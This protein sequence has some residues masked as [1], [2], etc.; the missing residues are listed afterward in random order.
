M[1]TRLFGTTGVQ[2][3]PLCLGAMMFGAWGNT[4]ARRGGVLDKID[5]IVPPGINLNAADAGYQN[6]ALRPGARRRRQ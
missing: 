1:N 5:E 3:S 4:A 2:V 6:P